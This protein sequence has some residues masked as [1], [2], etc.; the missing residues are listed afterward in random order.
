MRIAFAIRRRNYYKWLTPV[1]L[2]AIRRGHT[3]DVWHDLR[4]PQDGPWGSGLRPG[5]RA[6][7]GAQVYE[8]EGQM[9]NCPLPNVV[10]GLD[11]IE[12][13]MGRWLPWL[14]L[15]A[16]SD[17]LVTPD[18]I[19]SIDRCR[20]VGVWSPWWAVQIGS[21]KAVP[22]GFPMLDCVKALQTTSARRNYLGFDDR[23]AA[24]HI[25]YPAR[26]ASISKK[27]R[28]L[29]TVKQWRLLGQFRR[30]CDSQGFIPMV[31]TRPKDGVPVGVKKWAHV[32]PEIAEEP[33]TLKLL[34]FSRILVHTYSA[35]C[36]EA[37]AMGV[38]GLCIEGGAEALGMVHSG[39]DVWH[40]PK[41]EFYDWP[42]VTHVE[43]FGRWPRW[44]PT[45]DPVAQRAYTDKFL[46][47]ID[48][49][50]AARTVTLAEE[51][52]R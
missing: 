47:P 37:A 25:P 7:T 27:H 31:K 30:W 13:D 19:R 4:G 34:S 48:G 38:R 10:I 26:S 41:A 42:K 15:Q 8:F 44:V 32:F 40:H 36:F 23:P 22:V 35:A 49:Q 14:W 33:V 9:P 21:D 39:A 11:P 3:V 12:I 1:I 18:R 16:S 50:S 43:S 2:E 52:A 6:A 51:I 17:Q 20:A 28:A 45:V 46:G 29:N 24:L 5:Q